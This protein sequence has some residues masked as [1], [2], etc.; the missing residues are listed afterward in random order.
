MTI[1]LARRWALTVSMCLLAAA[2]PAG[3]ASAEVRTAPCPV[4]ATAAALPSGPRAARLVPPFTVETW[5]MQGAASGGECKWTQDVAPL[6]QNTDVVALQEAGQPPRAGT[7]LERSW[8]R[9]GF[10][11]QEYRWHVGSRTRGRDYYLY[12]METDPNG[13][14]VN[15][16]LVVPEER[17]AQ[18]IL[19]AYDP[20]PAHR[21]VRP[22]LGILP[23]GID[24]WVFTVHASAQPQTGGGGRGGWDGPRIVQAVECAVAGAPLGPYPWVAAGD[25]NRIPNGWA[26][27][28][29][30][31]REV[32][33]SEVTRP[34]SNAVIDYAVVAATLLTQLLLRAVFTDARRSAG[35][36]DHLPVRFQFG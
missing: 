3:M 20:A 18:D 25:W 24:A 7:T 27:A 26:T 15:M 4:A 10:T 12:W 22:A 6:A 36:S 35:Q 5:N 9:N 11:V 17:R 14:R 13:H 19:V 30:Q 28:G 1:F 29:T 31:T 8:T 32:A 21:S 23:Q 16:A 34:Q 33:P 2:G